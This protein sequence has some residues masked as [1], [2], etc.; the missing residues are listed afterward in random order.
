M[1]CNHPCRTNLISTLVGVAAGPEEMCAD[2]DGAALVR[3]LQQLGG[4]QSALR[5]QRLVVLLAEAA[6]ALERADDQRD[7]RK[8]GFGVADL[9]LVQGEGLY[10]HE[11]KHMSRHKKKMTLYY[12][13]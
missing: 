2:A 7:G 1:W 9:V 11:H 3:L 5:P 12:N 8:L 4:G 13:L 6:R 10:H